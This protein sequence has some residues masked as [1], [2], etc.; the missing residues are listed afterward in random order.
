MKCR[1]YRFWINRAL[2]DNRP[3][4]ARIAR[5]L[6]GCEEC[7]RWH[8]RQE[9]VV[10]R[11]Q[12][13][14]RMAGAIE[15]A[16]STMADAAGATEVA[17][18][19]LRARILNQLTADPRRDAPPGFTRWARAGGVVAAIALA[20]TLT[21]MQTEPT[22]DRVAHDEPA[23]GRNPASA[24]AVFEA[25]ARLTDGGRLLQAATNFDQPLQQEMHFVLDDARAVLRSLQTEFI[26]S[27]LLAARD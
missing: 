21:R 5:H 8:E 24:T 12:A 2:D 14:R 11:L 18:P 23:E 1:V 19:F 16:D 22:T 6:A 26:P 20:V 4:S 17:P 10:H 15:T 3:A 27:T 7:R 13:G 9:R 25:T